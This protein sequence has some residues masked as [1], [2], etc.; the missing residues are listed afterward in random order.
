MWGRAR[1]NLAGG[2][3]NK[4]A[5]NAYRG[6]TDAFAAKL[7][8]SG[9]LSWATYLGGSDKDY[10]RGIAVDGS[11]NAYVAGETSSNN[12]TGGD[13]NRGTNN[14][15][16]G[17]YDVFVAKL[18]TEEVAPMPDLLGTFLDSDEPLVWGQKF[19][20]DGQIKNQGDAAAGA[21]RVKFYMSS[22]SAIAAVDYYLGSRSVAGIG[23]GE[24]FTFTN[25]SLTLPQ[26]PPTGFTFTMTDNVYIGMIVDANNNVVESGEFNN[27]NLGTDLDSDR[28]SVSPRPPDLIGTLLDSGE[29][30][31]WGQTFYVDGKIKNQ[32]QKAAG[33]SMSKFYLSSDS[34]IDAGD[35]SLGSRSIAGI[36]AGETHAFNDQALMLPDTPPAG[37]TATDDVYIGMIV[38]A[39]SNVTESSEANNSNRGVG[40]DKDLVHVASNAPDLLGMFLDSEEPLIWGRSFS[41]DGKI[42]NQG[43]TAAGASTAKFYL[44]GDATITAGDYYLGSRS[45]AGIGAGKTRAFND[46]ALTLPDAP[47]AGFTGTDDV[48]IGMIIDADNAVAESDE[49][50]NSNRGLNL[51]R[52]GVHVTPLSELIGTS[53]DSEEPLVWGQAFRVDGAIKNQSEYDAGKSRVKFYLSSNGVIDAS[54]YYLG[55]RFVPAIAAGQTFTFAN[56]VLTLPAVPPDGFT[57]TD[58]VNI[59]MIVDANGQ[60]AES[61]ESNNSNRGK[62]IDRDWVSVTPPPDLIGAAFDSEEPLVWG[63]TFHVGGSIKNQGESGAGKSRVKFY[64]S[65]DSVIDAGDHYLGDRFVRAIAAGQTFTFANKVLTLPAAPPDGFTATDGVNIGMIVDATNTVVESDETNNRNRGKGLDRDWVM[66]TAGAPDLVGTQ[67]DSDEPIMWGQGFNVDGKIANIGNADAGAATAKFYLSANGVIDPGDEFLGSLAIPAIQAG[68]TYTFTDHALTLPGTP[69]AGFTPVDGVNIGMIVD[70]DAAVAETNEANNRNRGKGLDRDWVRVAPP[71][72]LVGTFFDSDEPLQWGDVFEIDGTI[73]NQGTGDAVASKVKFYLSS[74]GVIG[75]NDVFLGTLNVPAIAAGQTF[76]FTD[77]VLTLPGTPPAGFTAT[78]GVNIG[79]I[80]DVNRQVVEL[81]ESNN[82]NQGKDLDR[83]WLQVTV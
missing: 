52:D 44:S 51:D 74:N 6:D 64:L 79:M 14:G 24:T 59:G 82:A 19:Y 32:G 33:A 38:D 61:N 18:T 26:A 63:Q 83:D 76:T 8:S 28:A 47:P 56:K 25:K 60:V 2:S 22:D 58:G 45:I 1:S 42:K 7:T 55:D 12:F 9:S 72:D 80:V 36:G 41:V 29:P 43:L 11:G 66:I 34:V 57:A 67:L 62:D 31:V 23:V 10:G 50:N 46:K 78:D 17:G 53:F 21:S 27:S 75:R 16:K 35:Y 30:L 48:H 13:N 40:L 77:H 5:N 70:A 81:V 73:T 65:S 15:V 4:A 68:Q 69:P 54:D 3:N 49:T 71:A 20:V 37:F 39:N